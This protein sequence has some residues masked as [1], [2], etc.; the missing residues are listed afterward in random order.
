MH[1]NFITLT[2][3]IMFSAHSQAT[4]VS[5]PNSD[6]Q[7]TATVR[8]LLEPSEELMDFLRLGVK[9]CEKILMEADPTKL[10]GMCLN[11][12]ILCVD[13]QEE[14]Q[15]YIPERYRAFT[16]ESERFI[17]LIS[18]TNS[19]DLL[20]IPL[21]D[22]VEAVFL[23][24][25]F[26]DIT[27]RQ[28]TLCMIY[29]YFK[30]LC[31]LHFLKQGLSTNSNF[32]NIETFQV[33]NAKHRETLTARNK[34]GRQLK[35]NNINLQSEAEFLKERRNHCVEESKR[36]TQL[37]FGMFFG[38]APL[39]F[40]SLHGD[41]NCLYLADTNYSTCISDPEAVLLM[42]SYY[43]T[44]LAIQMDKFSLKVKL[45]E[46]EA[47]APLKIGSRHKLLTQHIGRSLIS[48]EISDALFPTTSSNGDDMMPGELQALKHSVLLAQEQMKG[49][50]KPLQDKV[51]LL[52]G[53]IKTLTAKNN[54]LQ[55]IH[56][57]ALQK[58]LKQ[59]QSINNVQKNLDASRSE[60]KK[61]KSKLKQQETDVLALRNQL[62]EQ[63]N[64]L[65]R[66]NLQVHNL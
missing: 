2:I 12:S 29:K 46:L 5:F 33:Q 66:V 34:T 28:I 19:K 1:K 26:N 25:P 36:T 32:L 31:D 20:H 21:D 4:Q 49:E 50:I 52:E 56:E 14:M 15:R 60:N 23:K 63:E 22:M 3:L 30:L 64:T 65:G 27:Q 47:I 59:Q 38:I 13:L 51:A 62:A 45:S 44:M 37:F 16:A 18:T 48:K 39:H 11:Y 24:K 7:Q 58:S 6:P 55:L 53:Q 57:K 35:G 9:D 10:R 61:L 43:Q 8:T 54:A 40:L 41:Y 42:R 17:S